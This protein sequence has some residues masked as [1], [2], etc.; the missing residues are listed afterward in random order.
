MS[1]L[2]EICNRKRQDLSAIKEQLPPRD[3]YRKVEALMDNPQPLRSLSAAL[4]Q[5]AERACCTDNQGC[6]AARGARQQSP[7]G[8]IAEFKRKSPSKGWIKEEGKPEIIPP[9]YEKAGATA[10][11]ILTDEHYFGGCNDYLRT[12]RPLVSLPIL[13]KDFMVDEYQIFEAKEMGADAV[14]LIAACLTKAECLALARTARMLNLDTL[15]E[16]HDETELDYISEEINVVG[17]NNRNLHVFRTDVQTSVNLAPKI[18]NE[19]VKISESGLATPEDLKMLR[20][21]GYSGFL[22]GERFMKTDDPGQA[23]ADFIA[24]L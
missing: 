6:C 2:E 11:S 16:I 1:I 4:K 13:R 23:L 3:L 15:L 19:F 24:K 12:A 14:L 20:L 18:P 7:T 5:A 17:V 9:A 8:I 21:C 22:M 10:L